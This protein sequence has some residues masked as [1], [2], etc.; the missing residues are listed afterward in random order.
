MIVV[1]GEGRGEQ[2]S[3]ERDAEQE[4]FFRGGRGL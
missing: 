3:R 2:S 4:V 1:A